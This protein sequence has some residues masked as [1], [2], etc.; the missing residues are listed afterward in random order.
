[1]NCSQDVLLSKLDPLMVCC[2]YVGRVSAN[3]TVVDE[4][5]QLKREWGRLVGRSK[6]L[7]PKLNDKML[8]EEYALAVRMVTFLDR[9]SSIMNQLR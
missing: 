6:P 3:A 8:E 4:S 2:D 7:D 5:W 1:M 9:Q